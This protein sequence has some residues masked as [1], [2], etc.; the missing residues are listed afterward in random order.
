MTGEGTLAEVLGGDARWCV[1]QGDCLDV[2][3]TL[4]A[5]CVDAVVTDPPYGYG[6]KSGMDGAFKGYEIAGDRDTRLR[7]F[8][9]GWSDGLPMACF[10]SWRVTPPRGAKTAIVW[11]KGPASGMGD[12]SIP[13]KCSWELCW[14]LG[15]GWSGHRGEGV[16]SGPM[17]P[18][19]NDRGGKP[20][21]P[22]HKWRL[23]PN[24]KPVWLLEEIVG[25]APG[26][27]ILDPFCGSGTTGVAALR[28]GRRFI[29]IEREPKWA[30]L[31]RERLLAE[32]NST[33]L[34][35]SRAGQVPLFGAS[36]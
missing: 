30:E 19:W 36:E 35:A 34:Q 8:V 11:N 22:N 23:H 26:H 2:L 21:Q 16:L 1:E 10:G 17:V 24:E 9:V 3:P 33:T 12:L 32:E 18:T 5:G 4:A 28:L 29:G 13:W 31:S 25:K 14:I 15:K 27:L 7:D 6:H 20:G